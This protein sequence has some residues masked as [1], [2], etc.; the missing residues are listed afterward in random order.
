MAAVAAG[1][2]DALENQAVARRQL[3]RKQA[4]DADLFDLTAPN[5]R[6][7]AN[8]PAAAP[9]AVVTV[10]A[11]MPMTMP[12]DRSGLLRTILD[13]YSG[14]GIGQRQ[15]LG[16]GSQHQQSAD[17]SQSQKFHHV[18]LDISPLRWVSRQRRGQSVRPPR[19]NADRITGMSDVNVR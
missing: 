3:K 10:P 1:D 8:L 17:G 2:A 15:R 19:R 13:R 14:A 18:H 5:P 9:A 6:S 11:V 4:R 7:R 12:A 16:G